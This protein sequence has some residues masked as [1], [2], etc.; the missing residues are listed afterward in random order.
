M[1]NILSVIGTLLALV[2]SVDGFSVKGLA[3]QLIRPLHA[4]KVGRLPI[5]LS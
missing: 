4:A 5:T 1:N 2:V 3:P